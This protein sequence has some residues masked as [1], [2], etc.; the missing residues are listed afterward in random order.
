[1]CFFPVSKLCLYASQ[2]GMP[3]NIFREVYVSF[4]LLRRRLIAFNNYRQL[5]HNMDSRFESITDEDELDNLGHSCIICRDQ[6]D[7]L[8]G[9]KKLP[10]C[11]HAF[12]THCLREWLVQQQTCPTCR[13]DIVANEA[14]RKKRLE[15]ERAA[16]AAAGAASERGT[17]DV[18]ESSVTLEVDNKS[19]GAE[20][21]TVPRPIDSS[22]VNV[23][24]GPSTKFVSSQTNHDSKTPQFQPG[25]SRFP[26]LY[27]ISFPAG[28]PVFSSPDSSNT[29]E[30]PHRIVPLGKLVVCTSIEYWPMPFQEAMLCIPDGYVRLRDVER[31][32][33]LSS[34]PP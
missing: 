8:G 24:N 12:H 3:I 30:R 21:S 11:G 15:Q 4:Q 7:L 14:R 27:R 5:T 17:V 22:T 13:S 23:S 1:M 31:F 19:V 33:I 6:M 29:S 10:G 16:A 2:Y 25:S 26:C 9:C 34:Q 32:L 28:A 18:V 20:A